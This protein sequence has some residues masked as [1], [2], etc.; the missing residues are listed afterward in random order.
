MTHNDNTLRSKIIRL[1]AS[2]P[3]LREH[4]LPLVKEAALDTS[5]PGV[6]PQVGDIL[7]SSWGYEQTNVEYYEVRKVTGS[8][9]V[10]QGLKNKVV[11]SS[12]HEVYVVPDLGQYKGEILRRKFSPTYSPEGYSVRIHA[13]STAYKWDGRPEGQTAAGWG[14]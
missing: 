14:H 4:L 7:S 9:I 13:S 1:A 2:R 10:I 3:D 11:R 8:I 6:T 12:G 5:A